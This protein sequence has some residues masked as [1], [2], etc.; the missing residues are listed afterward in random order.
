MGM[1]FH[2]RIRHK[3]WLMT[4]RKLLTFKEQDPLDD[5]NFETSNEPRIT[6]VGTSLFLKILHTNFANILYK[7]SAY[8]MHNSKAGCY[9]SNP[10]SK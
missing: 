9:S 8:N 2:N 1:R 10:I 3:R 5:L 6:K 7:N 4:F